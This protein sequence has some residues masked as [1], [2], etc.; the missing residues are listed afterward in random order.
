MW[1]EEVWERGRKEEGRETCGWLCYWLQKRN[2]S[3]NPLSTQDYL[4]GKKAALLG[5]IFMLINNA[6][7][8]TSLLCITCEKSGIW[9]FQ[10]EYSYSIQDTQDSPAQSSL[11]QQGKPYS[12]LTSLCV[13]LSLLCEEEIVGK[14]GLAAQTQ[15]HA[16][17]YT[18]APM[19]ITHR[20]IYMLYT[21]LHTY[22]T[23]IHTHS[24]TQPS[25]TS[26]KHKTLPSSPTDHENRSMVSIKQ[27][28]E[29]SGV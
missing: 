15:A 5:H 22:H 2:V 6:E 16:H 17:T 25:S 28:R 27:D 3:P 24:H 29:L 23:H 18:H 14:S 9:C 26:V 12:L 20:H 10:L 8:K 11:A 7:S 4:E 19:H 13:K 1:R 21:H